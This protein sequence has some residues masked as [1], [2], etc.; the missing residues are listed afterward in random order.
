MKVVSLGEVLW[1]ILP[2]AEHLGGAPCNFAVHAHNLGHEVCFVSAVGKD[3]R[4]E[5]ALDQVK[6]AG[7]STRWIHRTSE[8]PTGTV[9][10]S[11]NSGGPQYHI[12]RPA[13]Y[14]FPDLSAADREALLNPEPQ[15]IYYGTLQQMS[16][17][18]HEL[19]MHLLDEAPSAQ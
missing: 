2:Q 15:W 11:L 12:H 7:L 1:D 18:A 19:T 6:A 8:Y 17:P 9:T 13:A 14:D 5:L 16:A 10:V 3:H 4:G